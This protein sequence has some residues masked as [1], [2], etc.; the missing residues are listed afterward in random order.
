MTTP[1]FDEDEPDGGTDQ[2]EGCEGSFEGV[3]Y[4]VFREAVLIQMTWPGAPPSTMAMRP[5]S[6]VGRI[7]ITGERIRGAMR[8]WN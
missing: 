4:G 7:R 1:D 2:Y 3:N 8:I 6:A 5:E